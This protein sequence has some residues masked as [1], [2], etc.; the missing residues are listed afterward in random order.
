MFLKVAPAGQEQGWSTLLQGGRDD[1]ETMDGNDATKRGR[2]KAV[3][4]I[5][6]TI[7]VVCEK[8]Y[9]Q[10]CGFKVS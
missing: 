2:A 3:A 6:W 1:L 5:L 8:K 9:R 7:L 4:R 10:V